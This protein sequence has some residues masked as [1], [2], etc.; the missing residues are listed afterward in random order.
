MHSKI[1][2]INISST[3]VTRILPNQQNNSVNKKTHVS[4]QRLL[5]KG[6]NGGDIGAII[7]SKTIMNETATSM[8]AQ[9]NTSRDV[10]LA[11]L[12]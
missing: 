6:S 1:M 4:L 12:D 8:R 5:E 9:A 7:A 2:T 10:A 3:S 11:L